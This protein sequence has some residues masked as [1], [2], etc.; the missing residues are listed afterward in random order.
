MY[1]DDYYAY[2]PDVT[3]SL[4]C[5]KYIED[6]DASEFPAKEL[7]SLIEDKI[8]PALS[9]FGHVPVTI[10]GSVKSEGLESDKVQK[11]SLTIRAGRK[12]F[13]VNTHSRSI[14]KAVSRAVPMVN[15]QARKSKTRAIQVA[16][17]KN[18]KAKTDMAKRPKFAVE[19]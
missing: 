11:L 4:S 6:S 19:L 16:R 9:P 7:Y 5:S 18:R 15:S 14:Q 17:A 2:S 1:T 13:T 3:M 12:M 10:T 8:F